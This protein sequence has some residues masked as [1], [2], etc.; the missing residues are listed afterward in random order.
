MTPQD[1]D[2]RRQAAR[3]LAPILSRFMFRTIILL[4][5]QCILAAGLFAAVYFKKTEAYGITQS[6]EVFPL[7]EK[8][9]DSN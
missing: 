1:V 6:G 9:R 4:C 7:K 2:E 3:E 8:K 5:I